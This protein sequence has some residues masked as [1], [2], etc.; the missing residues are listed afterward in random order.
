ME[1]RGP[2]VLVALLAIGTGTGAGT[3]EPTLVSRLW[4]DAT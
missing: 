1:W 2:V 4:A 3:P